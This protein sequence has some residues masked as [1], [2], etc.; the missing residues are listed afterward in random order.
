MNTKP[1]AT[2]VTQRQCELC[3]HVGPDVFPEQVYVGGH[4]YQWH[5]FCRHTRECWKR[6]DRLQEEAI[7]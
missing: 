1:V 7:A 6:F 4:G 2:G 5:L 3:Q